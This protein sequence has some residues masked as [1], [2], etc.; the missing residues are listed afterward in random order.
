MPDQKDSTIAQFESSLKQL[1]KIVEKMESGDLSLEASLTSFEKGVALTRTCQTALSQAE[2]KIQMLIEE[3][4]E[5]EEVE[6]EDDEDD[7]EAF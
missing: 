5:L 7:E 1:E 2:Q 6:F 4:D 3:T